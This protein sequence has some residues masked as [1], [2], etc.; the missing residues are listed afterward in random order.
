MRIQADAT[1]SCETI[2]P[3][4]TFHHTYRPCVLMS[5]VRGDRTTG[6]KRGAGLAIIYLLAF[7]RTGEV[8]GLYSFAQS[9]KRK[10]EVSVCRVIAC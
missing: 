2:I 9:G 1:P 4:G 7:L 8:G 10:A 5:P 6:R 3:L